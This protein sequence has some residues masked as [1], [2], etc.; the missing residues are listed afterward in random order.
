MAK[1]TKKR[2]TPG[3]DFDTTGDDLDQS[4]NERGS[5]YPKDTENFH[6]VLSRYTK[7]DSDG[8]LHLDHR[9]LDIRDISLV[10]LVE[11]ENEANKNT[12][13]YVL[14]SD[15]DIINRLEAFNDSNP[16]KD[17]RRWFTLLRDLQAAAGGKHSDT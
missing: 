9:Y 10:E 17:C 4:S 11:S 7:V 15:E 16:N 13:G 14:V 3:F 5:W 6:W 1:R 8:V 2:Q 12:P